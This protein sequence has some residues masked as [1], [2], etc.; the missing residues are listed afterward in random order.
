[1]KDN[2]I[3]EGS[4]KTTIRGIIFMDLDIAKNYKGM[5]LERVTVRQELKSLGEEK[6]MW[7]LSDT[8]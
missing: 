3:R 6:K 7:C 8:V 1:V 4:H 5:M 2:I